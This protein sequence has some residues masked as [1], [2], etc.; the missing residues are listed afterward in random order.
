[1]RIKFFL[2]IFCFSYFIENSFA[3]S[4]YVSFQSLNKKKNYIS[5]S[6]GMGAMYGNNPSL[7]NFI[8]YKIPDYSRLTRDEQLSDYY[9]GLDFFCG[10]EKQILKKLSIKAE[11]S[12]FIKSYNVKS[13]P[14]YDFT[15][16]NHQPAF[17]F[18][19]LIPQEF[20]YLKVGAGMGYIYSSLN[21][22]EYGQENTYYSNG[23]KFKTEL[24]LNAQIGKSFAGYLSGYFSQS[25]LSN[26][27]DVNGK[28]LLTNVTNETVN[29]SSFGIGIRLGVEIFI[30]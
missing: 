3:D 23:F 27:K 13:F 6:F 30:F 26:L 29:L 7:Q 5:F 9:T 19:Y 20:S 8:H 4:S 10:I 21:L 22:K 2:I 24:V 16:F 28:E 17:M 18:F 12:Y 11:Y 25:F 14:Q 1:M 15:Y